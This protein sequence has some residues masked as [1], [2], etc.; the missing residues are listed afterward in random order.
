MYIS[1]PKIPKTLTMLPTAQETP[2][3]FLTETLLND[4]CYSTW[5][6]L[7]TKSRHV[8]KYASIFSCDTQRA[9]VV[10]MD[11]LLRAYFVQG[12][13]QHVAIKLTIGGV[14]D[15]RSQRTGTS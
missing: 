2:H 10:L 5:V 7:S 6:T 3:S 11:E 4:L 15:N 9:N 14:L 13:N 8:K 12:P 1:R